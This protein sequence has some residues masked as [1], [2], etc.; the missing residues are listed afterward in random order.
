M[1]NPLLEIRALRKDFDTQPSFLRRLWRKAAE[2]I[3]AVDGVD[4]RVEK[5]TILGLVGESGCGK[6]TLARCI[7][8]IYAPTAGTIALDGQVLGPQRDRSDL[9]RVQMIFQDPQSALDP[10]MTVRQT[11]SELLSAHRMVPKE[12]ITDRCRELLQ[13]VGLGDEFLDAYP[14]R[15]SGGQKQRVSTARALALE[16]EMIVAD[17]PTSALDVSVQAAI[18]ELFV[19]LNRSLGLTIVFISHNMAVVRQISAQLA[20]MYLGRI[21]EEGETNVV[22]DRPAHP[23][24]QVLLSA[25]PRLVPGR[26]SEAISLAGDPPSPAH[27]PGGC[28][29]HP[30]CRRAEYVCSIDDPTLMAGPR[31]THTA[32]CHFAWTDPQ[33]PI[34][35]TDE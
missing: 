4:L 16:P 10:R 9:R 20:V 11:I 6:S 34:A 12:R 28:R 1:G 22:F 3:R 29:F 18:L 26:A 19:R 25:V 8:G 27:I 17:E 14:R 21:V 2:P 5:G 35:L 13:L 15:L 7:V 33:P 23:Y 24:T 32:A 30:R 31:G